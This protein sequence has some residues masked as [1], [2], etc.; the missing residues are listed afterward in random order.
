MQLVWPIECIIMT[1]LTMTKYLQN[2]L[3]DGT[4]SLISIV[5]IFFMLGSL[6]DAKNAKRQFFIGHPISYHT[7]PFKTIKTSYLAY[8]P[9]PLSVNVSHCQ[10][11]LHSPLSMRQK[12]NMVRERVIFYDPNNALARAPLSQRCLGRKRVLGAFPFFSR[13]RNFYRLVSMAVS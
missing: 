10:T 8:T 1:I 11:C 2:L 13:M 7:L 3:R 9:M 6:D 4:L 5:K 12:V